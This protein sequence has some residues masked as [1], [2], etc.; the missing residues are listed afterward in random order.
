[1]TSPVED[2]LREPAP[3]VLGAVVRRHDDLATAEDAAQEGLLVARLP[4]AGSA[5]EDGRDKVG[6]DQRA[7]LPPPLPR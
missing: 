2:L 6:H 4:V 5:V 7:A 3:Q 1:M